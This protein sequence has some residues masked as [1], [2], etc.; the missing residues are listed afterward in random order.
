MRRSTKFP[1]LIAC[2]A[3]LIGVVIFGGAM[4]ALSWDFT[5]LSTTKLETSEYE[6][7]EDFADI[8]VKANTASITLL[9][10]DGDECRVVCHE[11]VKE[12]HTVKVEDGTLKIEV[13]NKK[14]W[15]DHIGINFSSPKITVYLPKAEYGALSV[16]GS[17]G[18]V[19]IPREL[20]LKSAEV[21]VS[22]GSVKCYATV[23]DSLNIKATTGDIYL[24]KISAGSLMLSVS[25]GRITVSDVRC[26]GDV[27]LRVSTGRASITSLRCADFTSAGNTGD[28]T[29]KDVIATGMLT[30]ERS[31]GDVKFDRCDAAEMSVK[32]DTGS[33]TGSLLSEKVF[34]PKSDTG[35]V[36]VPDTKTGGRCEIT[37]DTGNINI[38]LQK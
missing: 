5:K 8:S 15:Y 19:E 32:T 10:S 9:P 4:S 33:V 25:T 28:I 13:T 37:T 1:I 14:A 36:K 35:H 3:I 22:T 27:S 38:S 29:L 34:V 21:A 17:T 6:I 12:P 7:T 11:D 24:E 26:T 2:S 30:I 31:T 23:E 16:K 20:G 18:A